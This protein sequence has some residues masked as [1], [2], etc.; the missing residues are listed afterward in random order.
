MTWG[1]HSDL[2]DLRK[3]GRMLTDVVVLLQEKNLLAEMSGRKN[4]IKVGEIERELDWPMRLRDHFDPLD[5]DDYYS[6]KLRQEIDEQN[7]IVVAIEKDMQTHLL[8]NKEMKAFISAIFGNDGWIKIVEARYLR[9][10]QE[11]HEFEYDPRGKDQV[12]VY[13]RGAYDPTVPR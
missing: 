2:M 6:R 13:V 12:Q 1:L 4:Y 10:K 3:L 9:I 11:K 8:L 7:A 5:P